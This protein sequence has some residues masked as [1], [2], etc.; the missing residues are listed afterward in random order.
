LNTVFTS[1]V[2]IGFLVMLFFSSIAFTVL[3]DAMLLIFSQRIR[4]QRRRL[5]AG[6]RG[7][8]F[9]LI[10][11]AVSAFKPRQGLDS[12]KSGSA[13]AVGHLQTG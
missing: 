12:G 3:E 4:I 6:M 10:S 1:L 5:L 13:S 11:I 8:L 9:S 2:I 7:I